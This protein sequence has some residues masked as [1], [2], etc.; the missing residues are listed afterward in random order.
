M[1]G[2]CGRSPEIAFGSVNQAL[3]ITQSFK[4]RDFQNSSE[5]I[6]ANMVMIIRQKEKRCT[7]PNHSTNKHNQD[8][9]AYHEKKTLMVRVMPN[10]FIRSGMGDIGND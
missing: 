1:T 6:Y 10:F 4:G 9:N 2:I 3:V 5:G 8:F 7:T